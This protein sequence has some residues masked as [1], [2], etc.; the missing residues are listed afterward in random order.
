[1]TPWHALLPPQGSLHILAIDVPNV[2]RRHWHVQEKQG[3][4]REAAPATLRN[5]ARLLRARQPSHVL[6]A[7]EGLGS[8]RKGLWD[9]YKAKRPPKP[10]GLLA[11]EAYV[12]QALAGV[13]LPLVQV[14][15]LEADDVLAGATLARGDLPVVLVT[16]DRDVE[17]CVGE[18]VVV[19]NGDERVLDEAGVVERWK[20]APHRLADLFA[21]A[22]QED[23]APGVPGWGP[24]TAAKILTAAG[25]RTLGNLLAEG[26]SWWVSEKYRAKFL[27][28]RAQIALSYELV[29]LRGEE[30]AK[31]IDL[32]DVACDALDVARGLVEAADGTF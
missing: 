6:F 20:V 5:L 1:M 14:S 16:N 18:G 19:W 11:C 8:I 23:E 30:A 31:R 21:L 4:P 7:G 26:G 28:H 13:G 25:R 3:T 29:R 15:G 32:E 24:A 9:L 17:Q 10:D 2:M 22:G 12:A 27:E